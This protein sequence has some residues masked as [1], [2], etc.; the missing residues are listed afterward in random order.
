MDNRKIESHVIRRDAKLLRNSQMKKIVM[1]VYCNSDWILLAKPA[2]NCSTFNRMFSNDIPTMKYSVKTKGHT[3]DKFF[4]FISDDYI[5]LASGEMTS[6]KGQKIE[7]ELSL[8]NKYLES[9]KYALGLDFVLL[10]KDRREQK[11]KMSHIQFL[12]NEEVVAF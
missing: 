6:Q 4:P 5:I 9:Q 7:V 12:S 10:T 2:G 3:K 1:T 11:K 8:N